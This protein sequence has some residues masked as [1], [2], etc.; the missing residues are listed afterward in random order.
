MSKTSRALKLYIEAAANSLSIGI[1]LFMMIG[2]ALGFIIEPDPVGSDEYLSMLGTIQMGN[3]GTVFMITFANAK[4]QQSKF[5]SSCNCAKELFII[6]PVAVITVLN[7]LYDT[8]LAVSAYINLGTAGLSDTLVFDT[9][10]S[11]LLIIAGSCYGKNGVTSVSVIQVIGYMT[12]ISSPFTIG[13][14]PIKNDTLGLPVSTAAL[15]TAGGYI[16]SIIIA[17]VLGNIWWK[18]GNRFSMPNKFTQ[19]MVGGQ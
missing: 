8:V 19:N 9:I 14:A 11:A 17:I 5:Y 16:I 4:I 7:M 10:S 1:G 12:F 3:S 18:K 15:I 2:M 13:N 6:G